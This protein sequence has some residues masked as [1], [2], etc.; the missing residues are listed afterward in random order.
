MARFSGA[1]IEV[2][3]DTPPE[4]ANW[5]WD[6]D[7]FKMTSA[8]KEVNAASLRKA[9]VGFAGNVYKTDSFLIANPFGH[10]RYY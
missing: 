5:L 7:A 8:D 3:G 4:M 9:S 1:Q 2:L 10:S 6:Y